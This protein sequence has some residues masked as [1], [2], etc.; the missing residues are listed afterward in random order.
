M[1]IPTG[2]WVGRPGVIK[3]VTL[4]L[5][6]ATRTAQLVPHFLKEALEG[7]LLY[8]DQSAADLV[9]RIMMTTEKKAVS[10]NLQFILQG[11]ENL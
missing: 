6:R 1:A 2:P 4:D 10:M 5:E 9:P 8:S 3:T 7:R 11:N